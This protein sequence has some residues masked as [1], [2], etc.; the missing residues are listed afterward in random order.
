MATVNNPI[1]GAIILQGKRGLHG[2]KYK[3]KGK[4][5]KLRKGDSI[6]VVIIVLCIL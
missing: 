2:F 4:E 6:I 1:D 3:V 5:K